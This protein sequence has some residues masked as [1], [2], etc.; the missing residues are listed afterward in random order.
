[1]RF[2]LPLGLMFTVA[3]LMGCGSSDDA[4]PSADQEAD[5]GPAAASLEAMSFQIALEEPFRI[6]ASPLPGSIG[7][8]PLEGNIVLKFL[9]MERNLT[10]LPDMIPL[11]ATGYAG[12]PA[13]ITYDAKSTFVAVFHEVTNETDGVLRPGLHVNGVFTMADGAGRQWSPASFATHPFDASAAFALQADRV[14]PR[15]WVEPGETVTPAIA[16][17]IQT[18]AAGLRIRSEL[19]GV[20]VPLG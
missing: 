13:N 9:S 18:G 10:V 2:G 15:E 8:L 12:D 17:D 5:A 4:A 20:G 19:L 6:D 1:M 7:E 14:D 3:L 11:V 16:F